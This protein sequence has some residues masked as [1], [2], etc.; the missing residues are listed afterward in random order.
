MDILREELRLLENGQY[1]HLIHN[2]FKT[3]EYENWKN[4]VELDKIE[5]RSLNNDSTPHN[6]CFTAFSVANR[7][8]NEF[9]IQDLITIHKSKIGDFYTIY[10]KSKPVAKYA[11]GSIIYPEVLIVSAESIYNTYFLKAHQWI[12]KYYPDAIM[13]PF[14]ILCMKVR[15]TIPDFKNEEDTWYKTLFGYEGDI[16]KKQIIGNP[17]FRFD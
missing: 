8:F 3:S 5:G 7:N 4:A 15:E 16:T 1:E 2:K 12:K 9:S 14:Y 13:V 10:I 6:A 11:E 17:R